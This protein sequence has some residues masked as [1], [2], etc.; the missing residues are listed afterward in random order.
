MTLNSPAPLATTRTPLGFVEFVI[1]MA[2]MVSITAMATD[3][4]LPALDRIGSDL[5]VSDPNQTQLVISSLF[6]GFALGQALAGPMSDSFGRKPVIYGGYAIFLVGCALSL[7]A[8][9]WEAM[10]AGR[11]LQGFGAAFPRI[12]TIALVRDGFAGR[13]MA[14]I[15]SVVMAVFI[16]VPTI[17]PA[18]G[19]LVLAFSD[20][21]AMFGVLI[22]MAVGA[23]GWFALRQPETL[24]HDA[25]RPF[26]LRS[27]QTGLVEVCA[28]R[29]AIGYTVAAGLIF[30]AFLTYLSTAQQIFQQ[31]YDTGPLFALYFAMAALAI[32]GAS[33]VNSMLVM[34]LGMRSLT[35]TAMIGIAIASALFAGPVV[36]FDGVPPFWMFM[37]WLLVVFFCTGILFG[38]LN[39]IAMEP[40]GHI[41]GLGAALVGSGTTFISLPLAWYLGHLFDGGVLPL[42]GGFGVLASAA[43][44]VILW[45]DR[46]E[47]VAPAE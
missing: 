12:V 38:N 33:M 26:S 45:A 27:I 24:P 29:V 1:L 17:A 34:R 4:M 15:M 28:S 19:Q 44:V 25:R 10:I 7:W 9:S 21:H 35:R 2:F 41:A 13:E 46:D 39:A 42:I 30:G 23:C 47:N 36:M 20:W 14:R 32:G 16:L 22:A 43:L 3:V 11:V 37:L 18:V 6:L 40:L 8:Q 31:I 5:G